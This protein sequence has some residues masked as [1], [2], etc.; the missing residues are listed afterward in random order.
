MTRI[1]ELR[2]EIDRLRVA[3]A[4]C[5]CSAIVFQKEERLLLEELRRLDES[6]EM[7]PLFGNPIR[8][9][10]Q[11]IPHLPALNKILAAIV[12]PDLRSE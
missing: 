8:P 5:R 1:E 3:W 4:K 9:K 12:V 6:C 10:R 7:Q 11:A 2:A